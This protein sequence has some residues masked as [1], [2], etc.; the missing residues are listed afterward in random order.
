MLTEQHDLP[1]D[2]LAHFPTRPL[3]KQD[4][5][6]R[7]AFFDEI[8]SQFERWSNTKSEGSIALVGASGMGKTTVLRMLEAELGEAVMHGRVMTKV[9]GEKQMVSTL[10]RALGID[11]E[12]T[13]GKEIVAALQSEERRIIALDDCHNLFLRKIGGFRAW[14]A[15]TQVVS[16]SCDNVFWVCSFNEAAWE[17]L[18]DIS[19]RVGYFRQVVTM[20]PWTDE[21]IRRLILTRARRS[22]YRPNFTDLLVSRVEGVNVSTQIIGTAHGY[23]RLLWDFTSGNPRLATH[24][25]LR[26]LVPDVEKRRIRVHLFD[27]PSV[28]EL[29]DLSDDIAFVL[30]GIV[31][32]ENV[33]ADELATICNMPEEFCRFALRYLREAGYLWRDKIT[34]RTYLHFHWQQTVIRYLKRK[35]LLYS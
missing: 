27:S 14:E 1:E 20:P 10:A 11:G 17:Y 16:E 34:G 5:P 33:T 24:F 8:K 9:T 18:N 26:S 15:F 7:P 3:T 23:F 29:E 32:H 2:L 22:R 13:T 35:H 30:A 31:E 21:D 25:W 12:L 6:V 19:D 4:R 28:S